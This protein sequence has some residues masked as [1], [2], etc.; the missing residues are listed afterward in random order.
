MK[1]LTTCLYRI[2]IQRDEFKFSVILEIQICFIFFISLLKVNCFLF[3][4]IL[5]FKIFLK[6]EWLI[7]ICDIKAILTEKDWWIP[8]LQKH[9]TEPPHF[10]GN[11]AAKSKDGGTHLFFFFNYK[12]FQKYVCVSM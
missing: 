10:P 2:D 3:P 8:W 11:Q 4:I 12:I 5:N 7:L 6:E 9:V 1:L